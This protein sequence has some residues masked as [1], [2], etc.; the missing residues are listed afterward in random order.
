MPASVSYTTCIAQVTLKFIDNT[1]LVYDNRSVLLLYFKLL[2]DL[3]A[4]KD[5]LND[6]M[7][8]LA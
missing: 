4:D 1:L 5:R 7:N 3:V 8:F 6:C 2:L